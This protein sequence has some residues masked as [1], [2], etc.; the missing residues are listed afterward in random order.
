MS[1]ERVCRLCGS[2]EP[3]HVHLGWQSEGGRVLEEYF[4]VGRGLSEFESA[5]EWQRRAKARAKALREFEIEVA[6]IA[7]LLHDGKTDPDVAADQLAALSEQMRKEIPEW[8]RS[9]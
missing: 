9:V 8:K 1:T 6:S 4:T 3:F 5:Q 7:Q 2:T